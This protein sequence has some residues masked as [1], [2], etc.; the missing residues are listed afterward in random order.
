MSNHEIQDYVNCVCKQIRWKNYRSAIRNEL[1]GHIADSMDDFMGQGESEGEAIKK[2]FE[3]LGSPQVI[4]KELNEVYKP[5]FDKGKLFFTGL[6][7][8]FFYFLECYAAAGIIED[9]S[10]IYRGFLKIVLGVVAAL[11]LFLVLVRKWGDCLK[12]AKSTV[13][14]YPSPHR[15][16][17]VCL[18]CLLV[19][20]CC[21]TALP[22]LQYAYKQS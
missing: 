8:L 5:E 9:G 2:T 10:W 4:G 14:H 15:S 22:Y 19:K 18:W 7:I 17:A 21:I 16:Y 12:Q 1:Q 3:E 6:F 20:A 13:T 11:L